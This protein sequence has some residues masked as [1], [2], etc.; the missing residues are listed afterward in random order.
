MPRV[1]VLMAVYNGMPYLREA[2]ESVLSQRFSDFEFLV[3]DD[4][5][6]DGSVECVKS[7]GDPRIR[8]VRNEVNRG[9]AASLNVGL[10]LA[11]GDY[12]ARLDQDDVCLSERLGRQ[13]EFLDR[14]LSV[15]VVGAWT[16]HIDS[17]GR[18]TGLFGKQRLGDYGAFL[19]LL[20]LGMN[21]VYHS[22]AMYR[23]E[24]AYQ[25]GG[26]DVNAAPADDYH[27][28]SRFAMHRFSAGV[29]EAPLVMIRSHATQQ[30]TVNSAAHLRSL[31]RAHDRMVARLSSEEDAQQLAPLLRRENAYW[32]SRKSA[33]EVVEAL[34]GLEKLLQRLHRVLKLSSQECSSLAQIVYRSIGGSALAAA[35]RGRR[36]A[37]ATYRWTCRVTKG[38]MPLPVMYGLSVVPFLLSTPEIRRPLSPFGG[39]LLQLRHGLGLVPCR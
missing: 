20:L 5:S 2:I 39:K 30:T 38:R 8:L 16:Y 31:H 14:R 37:L 10:R 13:V 28:W 7:Y 19:G 12:I 15:G 35:L 4:A 3:V 26:Y 17:R 27:F 34:D 22:S 11:A 24:V 29:I 1:T 21:P 25:V 32:D 36:H 9:Q 23:R 18:K 33:Q 6:S